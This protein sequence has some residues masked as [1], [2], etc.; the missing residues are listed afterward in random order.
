VTPRRV[1]SGVVVALGALWLSGCASLNT[2]ENETLRETS[3]RRQV[4]H[5]PG[6]LRVSVEREGVVARF[7]TER[8]DRCSTVDVVAGERTVTTTRAVEAIGSYRDNGLWGAAGLAVGGAMIP[9]AL[10]SS[11]MAS[12]DRAS[13]RTTYLVLGTTILA[14]GLGLVASWVH[15]EVIGGTSEH[16]EPYARTELVHTHREGCPARAGR[17]VLQ[18]RD[19]PRLLLERV[20]NDVGLLSLDLA[21]VLPREAFRG[22]PPWATLTVSSPNEAA[23]VLVGLAPYRAALADAQWAQALAHPSPEG[24][25]R[26]ADDFPDDTRAAEARSRVQGMVRARA[27]MARDAARGERWRTLGD[28]DAR[29][30]AFLGEG[31]GDVYE[32][33]AACRMAS[34]AADSG[35]SADVT[36]L[37]AR[38]VACETRLGA[39]P[40]EVRAQRPTVVDEAE[41]AWRQARARLTAL[42]AEAREAEARAEAA[43]AEA[44]REAQVRRARTQRNLA[45]AGRSALSEARSAAAACRAGRSTGASGVRGAYLALAAARAGITPEAMRSAVVSVA[46]AC[47]CTP[48]CAGV[49]AP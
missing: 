49:P 11:D 27:A 2:R 7:R 44:E 20:T 6:A 3:R 47:R 9:L 34:R 12:D 31:A 45:R 22:R 39:M 15:A 23:T 38:V 26:F 14:V 46:A 36:A 40:E 18:F 5:T 37:R 28:D 13:P 33:A 25:A 43:R 42:E 32:A 48:G 35:D 21:E 17:A 16:R 41:T 10:N 29:L 19:G 8:E 30:A 1:A 4:E 24:L